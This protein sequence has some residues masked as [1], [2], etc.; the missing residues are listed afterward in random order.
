LVSANV[1]GVACVVGAAVGAAVESPPAPVVA[2]AAA[3]VVGADELL[4][5]LPHA[6]A[7]APTKVN[8]ATARS[9]WPRVRGVANVDMIGRQYPEI[10]ITAISFTEM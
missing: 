1:S 7:V 10:M 2:V 9:T 4:L 5:L 3:D 6:A 8:R